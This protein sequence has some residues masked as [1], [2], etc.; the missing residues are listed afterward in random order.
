MGL[1]FG[2]LPA[3]LQ[4][5]GRADHAVQRGAQFVAHVG[6]KPGLGQGRCFGIVALGLQDPGVLGEALFGITSGLAQGGFHPG[7]V[8]EQGVEGPADVQ[9]VAAGRQQAGRVELV[10]GDVVEGLDQ[11]FSRCGRLALLYPG[12]EHQRR[13][14]PA[15]P[16]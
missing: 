4:Q 5:L 6:Q 2:A 3:G 16:R 1:F 10:G 8:V 14:R 7:Q 13:P 9:L 12:M 15:P 11:R